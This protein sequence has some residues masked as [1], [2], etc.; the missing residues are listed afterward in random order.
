[1]CDNDKPDYSEYTPEMNERAAI[2]YLSVNLEKYPEWPE[3][4][5]EFSNLRGLTLNQC[6][7]S[8]VIINNNMDQL[9]QL[10]ELTLN[11]SKLNELPSGIS[12][13]RNLRFLQLNCRPITCL[14][15]MICEL[16]NL[17]SLKVSASLEGLPQELSQLKML[18]CLD[19]S[20]SLNGGQLTTP[21]TK[22]EEK[23][24]QYKPL[25]EVIGELL[26]LEY[27][28]LD[29]C[30]VLSVKVLEPLTKLKSLDLRYAGFDHCDELGRL[31]SLQE[32]SLI[33]CYSIENINALVYLKLRRLNLSSTSCFLDITPVLKMRFLEE[34][35]IE[36]CDSISDLSPIYNNLT[37]K[38]LIANDEQMNKW[39]VGVAMRDVPSKERIVQLLKSSQLKEVE[40]GIG[41]FSYYIEFHSTRRTNAVFSFFGIN[42]EDVSDE[43]LTAVDVIDRIVT[44]FASELSKESLV[45][46]F[47]SGMISI[48]DNFEYT[49][50]VIDELIN[51]GASTTQE[52]EQVQILIANKFHDACC[53]Y[54]GGHRCWGDT[55]H[56]HLID[57]YFPTFGAK[58]LLVILQRASIDELSHQQG[59]ALDQ[60]FSVAFSLKPDLVVEN[61]LLEVYQR[62][63]SDAAD[64]FDEE[65]FSEMSQAI[66]NGASGNVIKSL[67]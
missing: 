34:L 2:R 19:L 45:K 64:Y 65:Y 52:Q 14:P 40:E 32:L 31:S 10:V 29:C 55:V 25:P 12:Q 57:S 41:Y 48:Y 17:E 18:K 30:S 28:N 35:G 1:M 36:G 63:C 38:N 59:D 51:R 4:A 3:L 47:N 53:Y 16:E 42:E 5:S 62:Y 13:C 7:E 46:L 50:N 49:L 6:P 43:E 60:L 15:L 37:I 67:T 33:N 27:L 23:R 20:G 21:N 44:Q 56:D 66:C 24:A 58:S 54:D 39:A 9:T 8:S 22:T 61:E 11:S 26:N